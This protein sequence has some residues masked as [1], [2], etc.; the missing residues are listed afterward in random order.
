MVELAARHGFDMQGNS[1]DASEEEVEYD[2]TGRGRGNEDHGGK[3]SAEYS[4]GT[5]E[6]RSGTSKPSKKP[7]GGESTPSRRADRHRGMSFTNMKRIFD[8]LVSVLANL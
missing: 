1:L 3:G 7:G 2:D 6:G 5:T 4:S 8:A